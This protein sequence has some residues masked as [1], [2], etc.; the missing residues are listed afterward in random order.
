MTRISEKYLCSLWGAATAWTGRFTAQTYTLFP[1]TRTLIKKH[2]SR[3]F[4]LFR[5]SL[6][7]ST[8]SREEMGEK[9][10]EKEAEEET[11]MKKKDKLANEKARD[12]M[13]IR[14][15][16]RRQSVNGAKEKRRDGTSATSPE[17]VKLALAGCTWQKMRDTGKTACVLL[18][19]ITAPV[20]HIN[21]K[22][23]LL[24]V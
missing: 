22:G 18:I 13:Y 12:K 5:E 21:S 19:T 8:T 4:L 2:D 6:N 10:E 14:E 17:R 1:R 7:L 9:L 16:A 15:N 20:M 3:N 23:V 11:E 24:M